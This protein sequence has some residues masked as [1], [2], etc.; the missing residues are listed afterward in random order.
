MGT[1]DRDKN[2]EMLTLGLYL[3]ITA[4]SGE[5][6]NHCVVMAESIAASLTATEIAQC[7][8]AAQEKAGLPEEPV[9]LPV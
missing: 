7:Q 4:P 1:V 3:A 2:M 5:K 8:R 9:L 6:K